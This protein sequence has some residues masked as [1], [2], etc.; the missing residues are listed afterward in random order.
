MLEDAISRVRE[1]IPSLRREL[2]S[3][4]RKHYP[5]KAPKTVLGLLVRIVAALDSTLEETRENLTLLGPA[6]AE[7]RLRRVVYSIGHVHAFLAWIE[8]ASLERAPFE[9][10]PVVERLACQQLGDT[11]VA[12]RTDS[13]FNYT[14]IDLGRVVGK[15]LEQMAPDSVGVSTAQRVLFISVPTSESKSVLLHPLVG[16]ELGHQ[17]V[18]EKNLVAQ[19]RSQVAWD[20]AKV[21]E[22]L[23]ALVSTLPSTFGGSAQ[24]TLGGWAR[25]QMEAKLRKDL[26]GGNR[27]LGGRAS[28]GCDWRLPN[29]RSFRIGSPE[30]LRSTES[31][32]TDPSA[33]A[34]PL[35]SNPGDGFAIGASNRDF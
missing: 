15:L 18:A 2:D 1:R 25:T 33:V 21:K 35:W 24:A 10:G 30:L 29:R 7:V 19:V 34:S 32:F 13:R 31:A 14:I 22:H 3:L 17:I 27:A 20:N 23:D 5:T 28:F 12:V 11:E 4:Q 6:D 16:H 26:E 8:T 9:L